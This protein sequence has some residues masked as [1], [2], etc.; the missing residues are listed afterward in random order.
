MKLCAICNDV[1]DAYDEICDDCY[2]KQNGVER[3]EEKDE[4]GSYK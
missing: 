3:S 1:I 4:R 2:K